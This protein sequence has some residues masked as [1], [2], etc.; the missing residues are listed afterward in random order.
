[1]A[2]I[3]IWNAISSRRR[4]VTDNILENGLAQLKGAAAQQGHRV[5]VEDWAR[6]GFHQEL[7]PRWLTRL[8]R[9]LLD[10]CLMARDAGRMRRAKFFGMLSQPVQAIQTGIRRWRMRARIGK[11]AREA[12]AGGI[13]VVGMKLW[14]GEAL[15]W[16]EELLRAIRRLDPSVLFVAGG[17]LVSVYGEHFAADSEF[18]VGVVAQGEEALCVIL[19]AVDAGGSIWDKAG[20]MAR[21][22]RL[23]DDGFLKNVILRTAAG[24]KATDRYALNLCRSVLPDYSEEDIEGKGKMHVVRSSL[25]CSWGKCHF[26]VHPRIYP[27]FT[28]R[29]VD[30]IV[31]E[32]TLLFR[33]GVGFFRFAGSDTPPGFG[34]EIV[35]RL[36]DEGIRIE[37]GM[38]LRGVQGVRDPQKYAQTVEEFEWLIRGGLRSVFMGG[39]TGHPEINEKVMNKGLHPDEVVATIKA[40]REASRNLDQP[41]DIGLALIYPPP[42]IEGVT[43]EEVCETTVSMVERAAPDAVAVNPSAPFPGSTWEREKTRFG[44]EIAPHTERLAMR[45]EFVPYKPPTTWPDIGVRLN[46][47]TF[48]ECLAECQK[49]R[50]RVE[51]MGLPTDLTDEHFMMMRAVGETDT[52]RFK[53]ETLLDIL[54]GN[55]EYLDDCYSKM[56]AMSERLAGENRREEQEVAEGGAGTEEA[57][58]VLEPALAKG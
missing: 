8:C 25:G 57:E 53:R 50:R 30:D 7:A 10:A 54:S 49:L 16:A 13:K 36:I 5:V 40:L 39:E 15:E 20:V 1:M 4:A 29:P 28:P 38:G 27:G 18:D 12:V 34:V 46:G 14:Y 22:Q 3:L 9:A 58:G 19:D 21:L 31:R 11:L 51:E 6:E 42:L 26:C 23:A 32:I 55:Y 41:V 2:T 37:F 56:N 33:R 52:A 47:K 24:I 43:L 45:Y 35:K 48:I 17:P 44:F